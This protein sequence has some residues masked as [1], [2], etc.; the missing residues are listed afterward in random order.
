MRT[1]QDPADPPAAHNVER[2]VVETYVT[3]ALTPYALRAI[4]WYPVISLVG[5]RQSG[6]S[7]FVKNAFPD[8]TYIS[9]E[10]KNMREAALR[11]PVDFIERRGGRLIIDEAQRAPELFS[12]IQVACDAR[13]TTGQYILTGSQNFLLMKNIG[14]SLAGR[15]CL[16]TLLP[17]SYQELSQA[18][19][20]MA[21]EDPQLE[22]IIVRGSY[23]RL[24]DK[25]IPVSRF[26]ADYINTYVTRDVIEYLDVRNKPSFRKLIGLCA[27][28]AGCLLNYANLA[29]ALGVSVPTV[30]S[31]LS[32]LEASNII[33]FLQP[34]ASTL[35]KRLI[36]SPK[37]YF[38][39]TG[40]LCAQLDIRTQDQLI[41]H[42]KFGAIFENY[43]IAETLK[44]YD[45]AGEEPRLFFYRDDSKR[46]IDLLDLTNVQNPRAIE[47]KTN[48]T[49]H[50]HFATQ[51]TSVGDELSIP[52]ASRLVVSRANATFSAGNCLVVSAQDYLLD[53]WS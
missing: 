36:K 47:I 46:E 45:N 27:H 34:Y 26:Y 17:F 11:D 43:I 48:K 35:K 3:R 19:A 53:S 14:Q 41:E 6:K 38:L 31:W 10:D 21:S 9:L 42:K 25:K 22:N 33:Y 5:P 23:P 16:L 1:S 39:D 20:H 13:D 4:E 32:I 30:K 44:R 51:L 7:T 28:N 15:V 52:R 2:N 49:F 37:L 8:Y 24:Y 29:Q 18:S 12:A 50:S 40:L